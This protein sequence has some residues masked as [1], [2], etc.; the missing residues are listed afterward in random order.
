MFC[1]LSSRGSLGRQLGQLLLA[2]R[3]CWRTRW[4]QQHGMSRMG[5][6]GR[7][8]EQHLRAIGQ[9]AGLVQHMSLHR[10][11]GSWGSWQHQL[12]RAAELD[13]QQSKQGRQKQPEK[14]LLKNIN[15]IR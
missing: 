8:Q 5:S 4:G 7:Q 13:L 15:V 2:I 12:L 9:L 11:R 10:S 6:R 3:L 1:L 14:K